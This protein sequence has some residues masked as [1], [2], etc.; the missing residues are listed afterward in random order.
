MLASSPRPFHP[1]VEGRSRAGQWSVRGPIPGDRSREASFER[2]RARRPAIAVAR[3][4]APLLAAL[5]LAAAMSGLASSAGATGEWAPP[6]PSLP[7]A[8]PG[9][10]CVTIQRGLA[11]NAFDTDVS[12]GYGSW[13]AGDYPGLSTGLSSSNHWTLVRFDL[14]PIPAGAQIVLST[15]SIHEGWSDKPGLVRAHNIT[16]NW[17]EQTTSFANFGGTA[18]WDPAVIGSFDPLGYGYKSIDVTA[19]TQGWYGGAIAN[20]GLLLEEDPI[21]GHSHSY[22]SSESSSA[23]YRPRLDVCFVTGGPCAGK[24]DGEACDDGN[25]C[26]TGETCQSGQCGA[27]QALVC[28]AEDAC[29]DAGI[30]DPATGQCTQPQKPDGAACDDQDLCTGLDYCL[31]GACT[32]TSPVSCDDQSACTTDTCDAQ[33]GCQHVA[34]TC[35][36]NSLCTTDTCDPADGCVFTA[37]TCD[38][39]DACTNDGCD[40]AVGCTT[41]PIACSDNVECTADTCAA[42]SCEHLVGCPPGQPCSQSFCDTPQGQDPQFAWICNP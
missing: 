3:R 17:S 27:G 20:H 39:G 42:G 41:A 13:A 31:G 12:P 36:D 5:G 6:P 18:S 23:G 32:G 4:A 21:P 38:D 11:G 24:Q 2:G 7:P 8:P 22:Y 37:V 25:V 1:E 15:F 14:S 28:Q 26:T 29:H 30:C 40:P 19:I 16:A 33:A 9:A 34:I 35:T 10:T